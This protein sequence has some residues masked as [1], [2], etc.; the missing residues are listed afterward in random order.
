MVLRKPTNIVNL[1]KTKREKI[2]K[3]KEMGQIDESGT[4][5]RKAVYQLWKHA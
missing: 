2:I 3:I 4:V 1:Y 5:S